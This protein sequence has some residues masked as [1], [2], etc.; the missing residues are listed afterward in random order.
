MTQ[1]K[2]KTKIEIV[3]EPSELTEEEKEMVLFDVFDLLLFDDRN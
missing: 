1:K 2:D 3:L